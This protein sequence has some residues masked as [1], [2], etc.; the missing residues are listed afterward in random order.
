MN[1]LPSTARK[2]DPAVS[3][4]PA[5]IGT[6]F[7]LRIRCWSG[8]V[9]SLL[10]TA[11]V[12]FCLQACALGESSRLCCCL[13][14][15]ARINLKICAAI[16]SDKSDPEMFVMA[17]ASLQPEPLRSTGEKKRSDRPHSD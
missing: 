15:F 10:Q 6:F 17:W 14:S 3:I 11:F 8:T 1:I 2:G 9:G 12:A 13:K 7:P 4:S 5:S 16:A